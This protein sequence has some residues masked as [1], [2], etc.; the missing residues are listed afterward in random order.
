MLNDSGTIIDNSYDISNTFNTYFT[1]IGKNLS[2]KIAAPN[3]NCKI[4]PTSLIK[5]YNSSFFLN[6]ITK[7]EVENYIKTLNQN[8]ATSSTSPSVKFLKLS[9]TVISPIICHIFN[10]C[11]TEGNFPKSLKSAEIIPI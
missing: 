6:P 5:N 7:Y 9:A 2:N 1:D 3:N 11:I 4:T 10:K 8:K